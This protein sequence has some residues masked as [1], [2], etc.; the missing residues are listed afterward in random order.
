MKRRGLLAAGAASA[1]AGTIAAPAVAQGVIRWNMVM[2]WPRLTPGVGVAA[3]AL[4]G[5][6]VA[7][8]SVELPD[9]NPSAIYPK[10]DIYGES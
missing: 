6:G 5:S 1:A 8:A 4:Q 9:D 7:V 3:E 2:P 10:D